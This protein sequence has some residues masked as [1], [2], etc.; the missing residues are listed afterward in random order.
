MCKAMN[1]AVR[2]T[3]ASELRL[4]T[5]ICEVSRSIQVW[6]SSFCIASVL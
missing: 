3:S 5:N 2:K 4:K 6:T 1:E